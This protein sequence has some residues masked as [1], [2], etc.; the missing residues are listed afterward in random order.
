MSAPVKRFTSL[1][2]TKTTLVLLI[3]QFSIIST[4][5]TSK[6]PETKLY[7][8]KF[9]KTK[10]LQS[11]TAA[12]LTKF[13]KNQ[14][15]VN[16]KTSNVRVQATSN[17]P[18]FYAQF[19]MMA[20][21]IICWLIINLNLFSCCKIELVIRNHKNIRCS[22]SLI[23][24]RA[25]RILRILCHNRTQRL[26]SLILMKVCCWIVLKISI[27]PLLNKYNPAST[28][29]TTKNLKSSPFIS[30]RTQTVSS[31]TSA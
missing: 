9:L 15:K 25:T 7:L 29:S 12:S 26:I 27:K 6:F 18:T 19:S 20:L 4:Q 1:M 21:D 23:L 30:L 8:S 16:S 2:L 10:S 22:S 28:A 14:R 24:R 13:R 5:I 3:K 11:L 31:N 17:Q